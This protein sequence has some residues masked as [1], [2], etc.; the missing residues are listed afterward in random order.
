MRST[1]ACMF[2]GLCKWRAD[3]MSRVNSTKIHIFPKIS[4]S[5]NFKYIYSQNTP[6]ERFSTSAAKETQK[7][8]CSLKTSVLESGDKW[9]HS[10]TE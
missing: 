1:N 7:T 6:N 8:Q 9:E 2:T 5:Y 3:C 10:W 4:Q